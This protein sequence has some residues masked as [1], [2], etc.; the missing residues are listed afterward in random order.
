MK[1][2]LDQFYSLNDALQPGALRVRPR[3]PLDGLSVL[4]G[5]VGPRTPLVF[6]YSE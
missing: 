3:D 4:R 5:E 2:G 1:I 6:V